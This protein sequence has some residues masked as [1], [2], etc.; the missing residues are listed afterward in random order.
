MVSMMSAVVLA[1]TV[2]K[3]QVGLSNFLKIVHLFYLGHSNSHFILMVKWYTSTTSMV[4]TTEKPTAARYIGLN[5]ESWERVNLFDTFTTF[6]LSPGLLYL[7]SPAWLLCPVLC[8]ITLS[9]TP[10][11]LRRVATVA[12]NERSDSRLSSESKPARGK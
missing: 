10:S 1:S 11:W 3:C 6:F 7:S 12:L 2:I 4:P 5:L 9:S 8:M